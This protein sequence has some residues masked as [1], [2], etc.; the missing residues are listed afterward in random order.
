MINSY[1]SSLPIDIPQAV[2]VDIGIAI[3]PIP[4][5]LNVKEVD[6]VAIINVS[7]DFNILCFTMSLFN[8]HFT[9]FSH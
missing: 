3:N 9:V 7:N 8:K 2:A 4:V 6:V 5:R 1:I